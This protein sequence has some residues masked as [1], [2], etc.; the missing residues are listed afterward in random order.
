MRLQAGTLIDLSDLYSAPRAIDADPLD[1]TAFYQGLIGQG[2]ALNLLYVTKGLQAFRASRMS[3]SG[4][5]FAGLVKMISAEYGHVQARCLDIDDSLY[6]AADAFREVLLGELESELRE[7]EI[8]Y[9]DGVRFVPRIEAVPTEET[10]TP[11]ASRIADQGVYVV[12]GGTR[13]IG[14]EIANELVDLGARKLVLMGRQSLPPAEQWS[15]YLKARDVDPALRD[16]LAN[17]QSLRQR[18]QALE[19]YTGPLTDGEV[20]RGF[21]DG[22]RARHGELRGVVH[23]AGVYSD[24]RN[25]AF[26]QKNLG[27][28]QQ[29]WEPKVR[30]LEQLAALFVEDDLDFFL[31]FSSLTGLIPSLARGSSDYA[32]ANAFMDFMAAFQFHQKNRHAWRTVTW[33]DWREAGVTARSS[34]AEIE[35]LEKNL[36]EVGLSTFDN[37][38]GRSLFRRAL[39]GP[40]RPWVLLAHLNEEAFRRAEP[41]LLHGHKQKTGAGPSTTITSPLAALDEQLAAW[42]ALKRQGVP[43]SVEMLTSYVSIDEIRD[44]DEARIDRIYHLLSDEPDDQ[45]GINDR[46][47]ADESPGDT[48]ASIIRA[49]LLGLLKLPAVDDDEA[50]Q[51]YGLDSISAAIFSNR[52]EKALGRPVQPQWLL[53]YPTVM[54]LSRQLEMAPA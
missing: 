42:E 1:K 32:M 44:L 50:F 26:V 24:L 31:S 53:E 30:G 9:R 29:V 33:V 52:L 8:C 3:L 2:A 46:Q 39:Q 17:L 37:Q 36:A 18:V 47:V 12:T 15:D 4:S 43:C 23:A 40:A 51:N 54:A 27:E 21:F 11:G 16:K 45:A 7:T 34:H 41:T 28:M 48:L 13:G 6:G 35:R 5:K 14:L 25:P 10:S 49:T 20:L 38:E 19:I 22:V